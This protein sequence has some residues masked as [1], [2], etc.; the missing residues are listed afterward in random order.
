MACL[1]RTELLLKHQIAFETGDPGLLVDLR[2]Q[3]HANVQALID[4]MILAM[5]QDGVRLKN[6]EWYYDK[7][8]VFH[9]AQGTDENGKKVQL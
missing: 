5:A 3:L 4:D 2:A 1:K 8:G 6:P 7:D 9:W